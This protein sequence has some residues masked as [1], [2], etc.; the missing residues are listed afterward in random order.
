MSASATSVTQLAIER[1]QA[2]RRGPTSGDASD[3]PDL[4]TMA[5]SPSA[6]DG[7]VAIEAITNRTV[8]RALLV[9][10]AIVVAIWLLLI[11]FWNEG[12]FALTF[13]DAW[14]YLTIG[15]N[16]ANGQ[17]STFDGINLTNGYHPLWQLISVVP[18]KLG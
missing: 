2:P 3:A 6:V 10:T 14:Y 17:G 1:R 18:F 9:A 5:T 13:D 4:S 7:E 15:R 11:V 12:P 8:R 16:L